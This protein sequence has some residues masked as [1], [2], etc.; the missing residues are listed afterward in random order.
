METSTRGIVKWVL[1]GV[2][3]VWIAGFAWF[4]F[5]D[6][7]EDNLQTHSSST[8]AE[9]MQNC[10]GTFKQRYACKEAIILQGNRA[11]FMDMLWRVLIVFGPP[12]AAFF[13]FSRW[14]KPLDLAGM[15][16]SAVPMGRGT[17]RTA[18]SAKPRAAAKPRAGDDDEDPDEWLERTRMEMQAHDEA[19]AKERKP[20]CANKL[21]NSNIA[22][23]PLLGA[24]RPAVPL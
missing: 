17:G 2:S 23:G 15:F 6:M 11:S 1:T 8:I 16:R 5:F 7:S 9:R 20:K 22:N 3:I 18:R 10:E 12:V 21:R 13:V 14:G 19:R 4:E 24:Q